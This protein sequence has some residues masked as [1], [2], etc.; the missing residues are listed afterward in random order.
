M[1]I[2]FDSTAILGPMSKNRG[3]GN[4]ALSQFIT[5]INTDKKNNYFFINFFEDFKLTDYIREHSNFK[6]TYFYCGKDNF[7]LNNSEYEDIVGDIIKNYIKDNNID[8]FYITS[9]FESSFPIYNKKWFDNVAVVATVYDIIPYVFKDK[10]LADKNTYKWYMKCVD[11]LKWVDKCLVIS[12]SVKDDMIKYLNFDKDKIEVIYGA[13]NEIFKKIEIDENDKSNLLSKFGIK[14]EFVMCTGGD[15]ERKN[16]GGLI[17]A[18]SK[19]NRELTNKYQLV[20]VCKLTKD[21]ISRYTD[22]AYKNGVNGRVI[23]TNFVTN[24]ELLTLYNL[25]CLVAFPS[26]YEGFGLPVVEAYACGTPVLTSNNSSLGEIAEGAAIL[27][28]PFNLKDITRGL[29]EALSKIDLNDLI[30]KG[31][32]RLELYQWKNVA[33]IAVDEINKMDVQKTDDCERKRIAFFSPL[34]PIESGISDYSVDILNEL[35]KYFDIDVYIDDS[36]KPCCDFGFNINIYNHK[37]YKS[38]SSM[39]FD[40]IYQVGNSEYHMYMWDYIKEHRGTVVLHDYNLHG[41]AQF[42]A[43]HKKNNEKLYREYLQYDFASEIVDDYLQELHDGK[44]N[45]KIYEMEIN[46]FLINFANKII[47]HSDEAR[48]KLLKKD[49][50]RNVKTIQSY[51]KIESLVD[52]N[53]IKTN[54]QIDKD[55]I[56]MA[57][58]GHVHETKRIMPILNAFNQLVK[59]HNNVKYYFVGKLDDNIKST[60]E[61][62]IKDN[63]LEDNVIVTGYT[64]LEEFVKYIDLADICFNLRYPYNG[65]TS[66]SLMRILAKGKCVVVNDI[67]SFGE[68]P[69]DCCIKLPN[70][71][72]MLLDSEIDAIYSVMEDLLNKENRIKLSSNARR[73]AEK[74]LDLN[75]VS[76]QYADF[77]NTEDMPSINES[78]LKNILTDEVLK[79]S[80]NDNEINLLATTLAYSKNYKDH[81]GRIDY[82]F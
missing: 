82:K 7:L 53:E 64:E 47:V 63:H 40:V 75:I 20:I 3:I 46:S 59:K 1:N 48:E 38:K 58:F 71:S 78:M 15:D 65:E 41:V 29:T 32:K 50:H 44:T 67:G 39:Y 14:D 52:N 10:Y 43:L 45:I 68:I 66:G 76:N 12:K 28:D 51:A 27:V 61:I 25:A 35:S 69:D 42:A 24:D 70:V 80:Y 33:E 5:M 73:F 6:E 36:Y 13:V 8:L 56:I 55:T 22:I 34:P 62:F 16:I 26:K 37:N 31:F 4:Y 74:N 18:Y 23:F 21:S 19:M 54:M 11:M 9:P 49:I 17:E 72:I 30:L 79:K 77:I 81:K 60:F 2:A 57:S